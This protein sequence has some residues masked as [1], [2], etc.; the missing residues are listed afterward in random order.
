MDYLCN[1]N[2][3]ETHAS[4][5]KLDN[6]KTN[7]KHSFKPHFNTPTRRKP[8]QNTGRSFGSIKKHTG[9][10]LLILLGNYGGFSRGTASSITLSDRHGVVKAHNKDVKTRPHISNRCLKGC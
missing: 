2:T 1:R 5:Y 7:N 6:S 8:A 10:I 9:P 4:I 3:L